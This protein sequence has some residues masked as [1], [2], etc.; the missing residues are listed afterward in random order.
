MPA[1][2]ASLCQPGVNEL[3]IHNMMKLAHLLS[4]NSVC[5]FFN[6]AIKLEQPLKLL[7]KFQE[8]YKD[9]SGSKTFINSK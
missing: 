3:Y 1:V 6:F 2:T 8:K 7:Q 9:F 5:Q 4:S